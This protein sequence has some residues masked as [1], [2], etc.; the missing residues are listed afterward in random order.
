MRK[1]V[2]EVED[3]LRAAARGID[4][5]K[6][7]ERK[8]FMK[9]TMP[10]LGLT[11]PQQ[12]QV[13]KAGFSF[14]G[15]PRSRQF[16]I[17]DAVWR[18]ART[19]EGK[20]QP[21]YFLGKMQG[22]ED[23]EAE[24]EIVRGWA[25]DINCWDQSDGLSQAYSALLE[26]RPDMVYPTLR[27]WNGDADPWKR[28][29]SVVSLLYYAQF[30]K[31]VPA[32]NKIL[33]LVENLLDDPDYYVQKGVGWTLRETY[34]AYPKQA[35]AFVSKHAAAIDPAAFSAA[36]E[37]MTPAEKAG[38]KERRKARRVRAGARNRKGKDG[39]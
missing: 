22:M 25:D 2:A 4:P 33:P 30:R 1:Y 17:W 9:A 39:S 34:N 7:E 31:R 27:A 37:K 19:H 11:V 16:P 23:A 10:M 26:A 38:I 35:L 3:T 21:L 15:L 6:A 18:T 14:S 28:R 36:L 12:R 29:Q 20:V 32:L 5:A 8:F 24:W 13:H